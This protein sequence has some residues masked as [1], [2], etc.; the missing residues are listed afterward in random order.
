A[1]M[2]ETAAAVAKENKAALDA[3]IEQANAIVEQGAAD[4]AALWL[5][6]ERHTTTIAELAKAVQIAAQS[7]PPEESHG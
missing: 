4:K 2:A 1:D 3:H 6:A 7:T 5:E